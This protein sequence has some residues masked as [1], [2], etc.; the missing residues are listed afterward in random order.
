[1]WITL[2]YIFCIMGIVACAA[3]V[4]VNRDLKY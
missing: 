2:L 4:W 3:Q 1:M